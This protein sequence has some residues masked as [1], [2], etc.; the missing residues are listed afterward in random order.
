MIKIIYI[1]LPSFYLVIVLLFSNCSDDDISAEKV[2]ITLWNKSLDTIRYNIQGKWDWQFS[3]G[4]FS[5]K[6]LIYHDNTSIEINNDNIKLI[7]QS[8]LIYDTLIYWN[9]KK[10]ILGDSTYI[11]TIYK[12]NGEPFHPYTSWVVHEIHEDTLKLFDNS[13]DGYIHYLTPL[14]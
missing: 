1:L 12:D 11:M 5:G 6:D 10:N 8:D 2:N 9:K 3:K 14:N 13:N 4:G 7:F